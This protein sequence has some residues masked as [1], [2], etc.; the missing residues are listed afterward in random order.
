LDY[1]ELYAKASEIMASGIPEGE[2][3][4]KL[5]ELL[6]SGVPHYNWFGFYVAEKG[7]PE[8]F[9]GPFAGEPTEHTRIPF[10]KGICGQAAAN[11]EAFLVPDVSAASN[12]LACSI[13]V[14][15][16]IVIPVFAPGSFDY[17]R[18]TGKGEVIGEIDID[19]HTA[20]AFSDEDGDF[21]ESLAILVAPAIEAL[22]T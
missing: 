18:G 15:S 8:L 17:D 3:L 12:Y 14:K 5:C 2:R 6:K 11:R 10:G 13:K 21:L 4:Q 20:N 19:S 16:E 1:S 9:L 7:K 22:R